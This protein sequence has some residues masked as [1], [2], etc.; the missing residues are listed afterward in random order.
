MNQKDICFLILHYKAIDETITCV[1]SIEKEI[2]TSNYHIVIVDNGSADGTGQVLENMYSKNEKVIVLLEKENLGFARG[3]NV[4]FKYCKYELNA[5]FICA[6]NN[7]T[8]II[9]NDFFSTVLREYEKSQFGVLGPLIYLPNSDYYKVQYEIPT[10]KTIERD[11]RKQKFLS[12]MNLIGIRNFVWFFVNKRHEMKVKKK[13]FDLGI[14]EY[15]TNILLNG[16]CLVFSP[17]FIEKFDGFD[18]NTFMYREEEFLYFHC[19][20]EDLKMVYNPELK[21]MHHEDAS[22]DLVYKLSRK[23]NAFFYKHSIQSMKSILL[24]LDS[25]GK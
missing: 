19:M 15:H 3:N 13:E 22:T 24:Y 23:K 16:C 12:F 8:E 7:D 6:L 1:E 11:I 5:D 4:G 25:I 21:I 18:E 17:K 9:Q 10:R 14:F 2:D 20:E